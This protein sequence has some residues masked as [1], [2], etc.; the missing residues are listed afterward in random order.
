M[1][2]LLAALITLAGTLGMVVINAIFNGFVLA[3]FWDWFVVPVFH[4]PRLSIPVALGI[5]VMVTF[6]AHNQLHD[7]PENTEAAL[8]GLLRVTIRTGIYFTFGWIVHFYI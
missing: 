4:L 2:R 3:K 7:E 6:L 5:G 1:R 8:K